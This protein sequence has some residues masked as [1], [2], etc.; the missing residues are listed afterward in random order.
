[1]IIKSLLKSYEVIFEQDFSFLAKY[2]ENVNCIFVIDSLVY[3]LYFESIFKNLPDHKVIK[4]NASEKNKNLNGVT[5]ILDSLVQLPSKRNLILVAIGGGIIQDLCSFVSTIIYRGI[6]WIFIPTTLLAASDSC[7]GGKSS[8][9][10]KSYKN[11]LGTY[12]PPNLIH[13]CTDFFDS[14]SEMD[15]LSGLGEICKFQILKS[16]GNLSYL[17][18][19]ITQLVNRD[20]PLLI[21]YVN[22]SLDFKKTFIEN[23]EFDNGIRIQ[24]NFGHTFGHA[25]ETATDYKIPH[26]TAISMGIIISNWIA[27]NRKN[28]NKSFLINVENIIKHI[29]KKEFN[30][31]DIVFSN[32]LAAIKN[33]KKQTDNNIKALLF[34]NDYNVC[35]FN[36]IKDNEI[37]FGLIH[38]KDFL[39]E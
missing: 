32:L 33:D 15:Y 31:I 21:D 18:N 37:K 26:G 24:L 28:I 10:F 8:L 36:D 4:C 13:I 27:Y 2:I 6:N 1:M 5:K 14:L 7:I 20:K 16:K 17:T 34:D 25:I 23:D 38:L 12:S 39:F 11:L 3:D 30:K 35:L 9:N 22:K 29:V 19:N